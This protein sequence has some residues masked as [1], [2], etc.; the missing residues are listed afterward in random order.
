M[1]CTTYE[2]E[3]AFPTDGKRHKPPIAEAPEAIRRLKEGAASAFDEFLVLRFE[4]TNDKP[5]SFSWLDESETQL[6]YNA[7]LARIAQ[8]YQERG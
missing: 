8:A 1:H 4:A 2:G 7:V 3:R 6:D 5:F